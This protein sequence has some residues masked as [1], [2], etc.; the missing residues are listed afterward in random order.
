MNP[1]LTHL[2][3]GLLIGAPMGTLGASGILRIL[4]GDQDIVDWIAGWFLLGN[5]LCLLAALTL[6]L[7]IQ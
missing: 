2:V 1:E 4:K 3:Y 6:K 7:T 5:A